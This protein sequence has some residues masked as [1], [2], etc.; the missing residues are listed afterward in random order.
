MVATL[1]AGLGIAGRSFAGE[2]P[3]PTRQITYLVVFDPGG[4][5]DVEARRQQPLLE[6]ALGQKVIVTYK[7]GGG[8]A[9]GWADMV[10]GRPDG[11]VITGINL[12]Q[13][14][15]LPLL[16][17]V[18]FRTE[19]ILPVTL[20]HRTPMLMVVRKDSP[21][22]TVPE[23][24]E[25]AKKN[26][27]KIKMAATGTNGLGHVAAMRIRKLAGITTEYVP[28]TGNAPLMT[29]LLG[30]HVDVAITVSSDAVA[31]QDR[32]IPL[33][34]A[35][36]QR[37]DILRDV[38]TLKEQG[39]D[40]SEASYRGVAVP[41]GTPEP[42]VRKLEKVFLDDVC[43]NPVYVE[44]QKKGG[45]EPVAMGVEEAKALIAK[46]SAMYQGVFAEMGILKK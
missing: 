23:F 30:G 3:Y 43:K 11:Y 45:Y 28:F 24:I 16:Q 22:K 31:Y 1:L 10:R 18:G 20:F 33:G 29:A 42:I 8:G 35:S 41:V 15:I 32:A 27:G 12:P 13:I 21:F 38:P 25:A 14:S 37:V 2:M 44:T 26:P 4:Q 46:G 17:D 34:I 40:F 19:Q 6:K 7:P 9:L 5:S 39:I 36:E